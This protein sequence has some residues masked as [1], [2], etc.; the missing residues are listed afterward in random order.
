MRALLSIMMGLWMAISLQAQTPALNHAGHIVIN[1]KVAGD[2]AEYHYVDGRYFITFKELALDGNAF[3]PVQDGYL[4]LE[5]Y[6]AAV[7]VKLRFYTLEGELEKMLEFRR[8]YNIQFSPDGSHLVF[9]DAEKLI[10]INTLSGDISEYPAAAVFSISNQ[11]EVAYY[12]ENEQ[13]L[14]FGKQKYSLNE[15]PHQLLFHNQKLYCFARHHLFMVDDNE[16]LLVNKLEGSFFKALSHQDDLYYS[17]K[18]SFPDHFLFQLFK[19]GADKQA[20]KCG[21]TI[22]YRNKE[23]GSHE[24]IQ[25]PLKYGQTFEHPIGNTYGEIQE[26][27]SAVYLHPGVD[28]LGEPNENVYAVK[29]GVVKAV[30]TTGGSLYWRLATGNENTASETQGYLYAHLIETSIPFT[31]GDMVEAGDIVGQL[32]FW[33]TSS[34]THV[35]FARVHSTGTLWNGAWWTT[36]DPLLDVAGYV[37]NTAPVFEN[38]VNNQL[39]AFRNAANTYLN[40]MQLTE[41]VRIISKVHDIANSNWRVDVAEIGYKIYDN[42]PLAPLVEKISFAYDFPLDTYFSDVYDSMVRETIYSR[43]GV[44]FST[45]NYVARDFFQIITSTSGDAQVNPGDKDIFLDTRS[46]PNGSYTLEVTAKDAAGNTSSASMTIGITNQVNLLQNTTQPKVQVFN[47]NQDGLYFLV[48]AENKNFVL[49]DISGRILEK[50]ITTSSAHII[51]LSHYP[52]GIYIIRAE[53]P[54]LHFSHKIVY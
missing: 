4:T 27:G 34:F 14:H 53:A 45:G 24:P 16:L 26:Y 23:R 50:F 39:F 18:T 46:L 31:T 41:N 11:G 28:F 47:A 38:A 19:L 17:T 33:P 13:V 21:H 37:D 7:P 51:E 22:H 48:N 12:A 42:D 49:A 20:V 40:P 15:H 43:D 3:Y 9:F 35:H 30:L 1:E 52:R 36:N 29:G 8:V 10:G 54:D 25:S 2:E 5:V 44:C 32:I 6:E